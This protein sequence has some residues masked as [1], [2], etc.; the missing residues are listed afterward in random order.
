MNDEYLWNGTGESEPEIARLEKALR[1]LRYEPDSSR[2]EVPEVVTV[3]PVRRFR[4]WAWSLGLAAAALLIAFSITLEMRSREAA[5]SAWKISWNGAAARALS[6]GQLIETG[7]DSAARLESD[8]IGEV[9]VGPESRLRVM[10]STKDRQQFALERGVIHA[11]IW[12]PPKEFVVD[13]PSAKTIDLGCQYTLRVAADGTGVLHVQTGWVAFE[14][15]NLESFIPAGATCNTRPAQGP[16]LPYFDDAPGALRSA[17]NKFDEHPTSAAVQSV[18][19]SATPRDGLTLWHLLARTK[20]A[21]RG[22]VFDRF[23][24]LVKIPASVTREQILDGNPAAID[25]AWD[26]LNLGDTDWW[27]EWKRK[28]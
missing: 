24:A 23:Q 6:N 20:G 18:L 21:D 2:F 1:P 8:F 27:R 10:R 16:G 7:A 12:A 11:L 4:G 25:A 3:K 5:Q 19:Q 17:V 22:E 26:A 13:T 28:W 15:R 14:W 9:S